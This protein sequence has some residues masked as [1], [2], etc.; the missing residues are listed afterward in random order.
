[1]AVNFISGNSTSSVNVAGSTDAWVLTQGSGLYANSYG[2]LIESGVSNARVVIE[3][4]LVTTSAGVAA[5]AGPRNS[6]EIGSEGSIRAARPSTGVYLLV[7]NDGDQGG[8]VINEGQ[9][10]AGKGVWLEGWGATVV[11]VGTISTGSAAIDDAIGVI[12]QDPSATGYL[13]VENSGLISAWRGV[14]VEAGNLD[15]MSKAGQI[16]NTGTISAGQT[17]VE[18]HGVAVLGNSGVINAPVGVV[19]AGPNDLYGAGF[20]QVVN[21]GVIS[22]GET[23]VEMTGRAVLDN[24][25]V[26]ETPDFLFRQSDVV[27][28]DD[29]SQI[30]TNSGDIR[31]RVNLGGGNDAFHMLDG[32]L[33]GNVFLGAG[34]D[35]FVYAGGTIEPN[36]GFSQRTEIYGGDGNDVF[37]IYQSGAA[38]SGGAGEDSVFSSVSFRITSSSIERLF[39]MGTDD[40]KGLGSNN[41]DD[42]SGNAGANIIRG[43]AGDDT[44][45]SGGGDDRIYGGRGNDSIQLGE[46]DA[47]VHGGHGDDEITVQPGST[48]VLRG[49][50][51]FDTV[52]LGALDI[53]KEG[54]IINLANQSKN[55]GAAEGSRFHGLEAFN[56]SQGY[57]VIDGK[58]FGVDDVFRGLAAD[59]TVDGGVGDDLLIGNDGRD[60]LIGDRG[61]DTLTGGRG[62]DRLIGGR[63]ADKLRGGAGADVFV[64]EK[65][66]DSAPG[67]A[68]VI[69]DFGDGPDKIDLGGIDADLGA[70]GDQAFALAGTKF[71]GAAGELIIFNAGGKTHVQGDVDGDGA[72]DLAIILNG[73]PA[74]DAGDFLL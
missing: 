74:L 39:L 52:N 50:A 56:F 65:V 10:V 8:S 44:I 72:A 71:T 26:I 6:V 18:M 5:N 2:F 34:D 32:T 3:G 27:S 51:G 4:D 14:V 37:E 58:A 62:A 7:Q 60:T 54:W 11:N 25:G 69:Q 13:R 19:V 53:E 1:M 38:I 31:G 28:G 22:G 40:I 30:V 33:L 17:A 47:M 49:G 23:A 20:G 42:I 29:A 63:D 24:T 36:K 55:A 21:S 68:D 35:L 57:S 15:A 41:A 43:Y 66:E 67:A 73:K 12:V 45:S 59:E 46:G 70:A 16:V 48:Y 64:F 61:A 9:I